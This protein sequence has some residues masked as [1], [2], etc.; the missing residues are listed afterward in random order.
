MT[1]VT[2]VAS[3]PA[4][5]LFML[6]QK[7]TNRL[8]ILKR[9]FALG[10]CLFALCALGR[11]GALTDVNPMRMPAIGD[12]GVRVLTPT[13]L[14]VSFI[15]TKAK[16]PATLS[17]WNFVDGSGNLSAPATSE[18][19]VTANGASI[20]VQ[21]VGFKRRPI[22][23]PLNWYELH[24][25]NYLYLQLASPIA[26]GQ[27]VVVKNPSGKLW[28]SDKTYTTLT[29]PL[30]Y[31]PAIHVNQE[32]YMPNYA[33]KAMVGY[34]LG[35]KGELTVPTAGGFKIVDANSGATAFSGTLA[36]RKDVGYSY[37]PTPY[38]QVYEAD[39][40]AFKTPGEYRLQ[41]P[42]MGASLAFMIDDGIA[43][44]FARSYALG[45]YHQRCGH[46]NVY[47]YTR[48]EKGACHVPAVVV[49]DMT[50]SAV[51][52]ELANM[53]GD[54]A[55]SQAAGVPQLKDL[56]S[57]LYPFVNKNPINLRGGHHDA[58]DYSKYTIN[59]AQLAHALVFAVDA[60]PGVQ[61]LDNMGLPE[62]GDA[63]PDVLQEAK[64]ELD[65]L[66]NLQDTDGGFYFLVYPRNREY[67]DNVSLQGTD[68]GDSQVVFPK[69]TSVTAAGAAALAQAASSPTFKKYYPTQAA[70]YLAKAKLAWTFLQT[71]WS[72]YG[73]DGAYQKITHYGNEFGDK[74]EVT[75]LA[76]E[77]YLATGDAT[78]HNELKAHFDPAD[79][80]TRRWTWWRMFEGYGCAIRSY[81]FAVKSGRMTSSQLDAAFLAKCE[82]E[83]IAA[84]DDQV[85]F[86]Q[87]NSYGSSFPTPNKPYRSAGWF[88]SVDQT[89]DVATAY[90]VSAKQSY[91][92]TL[93]ANMNF[94]AG[95]NPNNVGFLT[96]IGWKRQRETVNQYAMN[97]RR[98]LPPSGIPIG[99][100]W[101]GAPYNW[102]YGNTMRTVCYPA[103]GASTAPYAPYEQWIDAFNTSQEMVNPQQAHSLA[104]MA[105]LMAQT[106]VKTQAWKPVLGTISGLPSTVP[107]QQT[108]TATLSAPGIDLSKAL[109]TW[110]ARDQD[111]TAAQQFVFSAIN[112]GPQWVEAEALLPDGRRVFAKTEFN[113]TTAVNTPPNSNQSTPIG[114]AND[115]AALYHLDNTYIDATGKQ[116]ALTVA[117]GAAFDGSNLGWMS[118]RTGANLHVQALGDQATVT[119]AESAVCASDT[120]AIVLDAMVYINAYKGYNVANSHLISLVNNWN[121]SLELN[122]DMYAGPVFRGGNSWDVRGTTVANALTKNVWHHLVMMIDKT[123]YSVKVDG[124]TVASMASGDLANW[125]NSGTA[126]L[127]LGNF[128]GW[129]DEVTVKH[130]GTSTPPT[131]PDPTPPPVVVAAPTI[132]P[133]GGTFTNFVSVSLATTTTGATIRYTTDGSTPTST[134]TQY[135]S[136]FTLTSSA[137]V[138]AIAIASSTSSA[139]TSAN[140]VVTTVTTPPVPPADTNVVL[141]GNS[142]QFIQ[143]DTTTIG[144]WKNVYGKEGYTVVGDQTQYPSYVNLTPIGKSEWVW[145]YSDSNPN[146]L[147]TV[148]SSTRVAACWYTADTMYT[149]VNITD[150]KTHR[151]ALYCADW[152]KIG[153]AQTVDVLDAVSGVVLHSK[154]IS[155]FATGHYLVWNVS[156]HVKIRITRTASNNAV[157]QGLFFDPASSVSTTNTPPTTTNTP[158]VVVTNTAPVVSIAAN[159]ASFIAPATVTLT[160]NATDADGIAKVE[161]FQGTTSLGTVTTAPYTLVWNNVAAGN[162]SVTAK[163][164]DTLGLSTTSSA[165]SIAVTTPPPAV[166]AT[167]T[168]SPNGGTFTNSVTVS[169]ATTTSAAT[170]RYTI[171]GSTPTSTSTAYTGAFTL[172]AS[173]TVK[174]AA[175]ASGMTASSVASVSFTVNKPVVLGNSA[176]FVKADT[177]T[178][179]NWK[180]VYGAEGYTIVGDVTKAPTYATVTTTGATGWIWKNPDSNAGSPLKVSSTTARIAACW[181]TP[182]S[183]TV[184]VKATDGKAHQLAVYAYDWDNLG[185]AETIEILD[186]TTGA[187]L[188][189]QSVSGFSGGR[190]LVW[191]VSGNVK[192]RVTRTGGPNAVINGLFFDSVPVL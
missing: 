76:T 185:R 61:S 187:V 75:W 19:A 64:W 155:S 140:L 144:D 65:F 103:D 134:S 156:G 23:A 22:Y 49:P 11:A 159:G 176:K 151:M 14:E 15:N 180:S 39:F 160:A 92:D 173:A 4:L 35:N 108:V 188:N 118:T 135:S 112:T 50:F 81:A 99:N 52:A 7:N 26:D 77:L 119:F 90:Q 57:S 3:T 165:I 183:Y 91:L 88:F 6:E 113:A 174:A 167:P 182:T 43:G 158:P 60:F 164:T 69:T 96:G 105:F 178:R 93:V 47:P 38:Q 184:N 94:E 17:D 154:A 25:G 157:I 36:L 5:M 116:K 78:Y 102:Q 30:R 129:V 104:S 84:G 171:D 139:V 72:K 51:N 172:T 98:V 66:A 45:L 121:S 109:I 169:L 120:T 175:F 62:S 114:V 126:T 97:D 115:Q 1:K 16:D 12:Y 162:Y 68:L 161:F 82:A 42:G 67:E 55:N 145:S 152:D 136:A 143:T 189:S 37:A 130:I 147:Q 33:K 27:T 44:L 79:P 83:I 86:S 117:G 2:A 132:A 122:E 87:D 168:I 28:T 141:S 41:V 24:I 142:V 170:I 190:Y 80:N 73:R 137:T 177:T 125:L 34:Y 111:P 192:V 9:L 124:N 46:D 149:D 179:G 8:W 150:G 127:T 53:T 133:N 186:A 74:D 85:K 191:N 181:Y 100:I 89:F 123:G 10:V 20:S 128:D 107:A 148:A 29:D 70:A 59:V 166:V 101:A 138:K 95:C 18:F 106:S 56:N 40:T 146:S 63:I 32:G 153:R 31:N 21:S 58:G 48:H 163:A 131:T 13:L 54:Y 71:A 110:E